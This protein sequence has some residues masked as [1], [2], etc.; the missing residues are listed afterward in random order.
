MR[1]KDMT[2]KYN[3]RGGIIRV[4]PVPTFDWVFEYQPI[5]SEILT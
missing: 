2:L 5:V 1:E 4:E 3:N